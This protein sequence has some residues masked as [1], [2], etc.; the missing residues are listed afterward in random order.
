VLAELPLSQRPGVRAVARGPWRHR[1]DRLLGLV[2][3]VLAVVRPVLVHAAPEGRDPAD[4]GDDDSGDDVEEA[5]DDAE[6]EDVEE[7]RDAGAL[8]ELGPRTQVVNSCCWRALREA[9]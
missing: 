1:V 9:T 6:G 4:D 3:R 5:A 8:D 2:R 7:T